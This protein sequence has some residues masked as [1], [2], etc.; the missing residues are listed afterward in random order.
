M[1][2][3]IQEKERQKHMINMRNR[4][5]MLKEK[6]NQDPLL[7]IEARLLL[8]NFSTKK[9]I[10]ESRCEVSLEHSLICNFDQDKEM[11]VLES[12]HHSQGRPRNWLN[13]LKLHH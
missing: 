10:K 6:V 1:L 8:L 5:K 9:T 2:I 7:Q 4:M 3:K 11:K 13:K 12:P